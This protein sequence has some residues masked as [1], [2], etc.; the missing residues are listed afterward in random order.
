MFSFF[1]PKSPVIKDN[2][3]IVWE[4]CTKSH[5]EVI[6]GFVKY[7]LDLG[8]H[9]SVLVEPA[10]LKDG[11]FCRFNHSNL[12]LNKLHKKQIFKFFQKADLS[13]LK[14]VMV[15]TCGKLCDGLDY[16][17]CF[18]YF[19]PTLDRNKIFL[20]EHKAK[21]AIDNGSWRE[22]NITLRKLDYKGANSVVVNPHYF[23][24]GINVTAKNSDI[25]NF[26]TIGAIRDRKKNT[27]EIVDAVKNLHKKGITNFK[28]TVIGKGHIK[29]LPKELRKYFVMK[30]HLPFNKMYDEIE[31]A[32][33]ILT[34]YDDN[35]PVHARY[36]KYQTSGNFQLVYGFLKPIILVESFGNINGFTTENSILY[37]TP[38]DLASAMEKGILL[39]E[40]EYLTMQNNLKKYVDELYNESLN[41]LRS[42]ING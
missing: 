21:P 1:K 41:N 36:T 12:T 3:V 2:T 8:Y 40:E 4:P 38:A 18:E 25:T 35:N 14:G 37:K 31:R 17:K 32:D 5:S 24:E 15:T 39:S 10:R 13:G 26:V 20:V 19:N 7:F 6:P 28:V 16:E 11:L 34:S 30:G 23:G 9:V 29:D 33:F 42:L 27:S 22:K